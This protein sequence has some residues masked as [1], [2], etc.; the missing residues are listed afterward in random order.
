[1]LRAGSHV[2]RCLF[3]GDF[4]GGVVLVIARIDLAFTLH[5]RTKEFYEQHAEDLFGSASV[6]FKF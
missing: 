1:M 5:Y 6:S 3:V 2:A 4:Q